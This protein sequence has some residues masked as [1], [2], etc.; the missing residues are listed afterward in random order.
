MEPIR[1]TESEGK[2]SL[3]TTQKIVL[4]LTRSRQPSRKVL[5]T[6]K[7]TKTKMKHKGDT[8]KTDTQSPFNICS[9][10]SKNN[11]ITKTNLIFTI[12]SVYYYPVTI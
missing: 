1:E 6:F 10:T 7:D 8:K 5:K 12:P 11:P 9:F 4:V 2:Y 3:V